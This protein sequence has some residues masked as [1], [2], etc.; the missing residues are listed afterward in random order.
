[1]SIQGFIQYGAIFSGIM[2]FKAENPA[3]NKTP[4]FFSVNYICTV[5]RHPAFQNKQSL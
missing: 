3:V 2:P 5:S 1:M 4:D